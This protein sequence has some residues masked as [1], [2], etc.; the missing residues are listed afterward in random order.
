[1]VTT[2][3]FANWGVTALG[4]AASYFAAAYANYVGGLAPQ[5]SVLQFIANF[6]IASIIGSWVLA[7]SARR[8]KVRAYDF[9]TLIAGTW[10]LST[11]LYLLATRRWR[12]GAVIISAFVAAWLLDEAAL[13]I[14]SHAWE[15]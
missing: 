10:M 5:A 6:L 1:M 11:P 4:L 13:T 7:D 15:R 9:D 12:G 2:T 14:A 3:S 8:G